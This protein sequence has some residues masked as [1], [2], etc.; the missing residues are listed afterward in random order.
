MATGWGRRRRSRSY[1]RGK[2]EVRAEYCTKAKKEKMNGGAQVIDTGKT[3]WTDRRAE[4]E[5]NE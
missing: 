2:A 1:I 5:D 3:G 4:Y